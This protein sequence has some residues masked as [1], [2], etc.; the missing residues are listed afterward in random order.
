MAEYE[1]EM[2]QYTE[3][4]RYRVYR[5]ETKRV[6]IADLGSFALH[7]EVCRPIL[8]LFGVD[9]QQQREEQHEDAQNEDLREESMVES[10]SVRGKVR[11]SRHGLRSKMVGITSEVSL[12]TMYSQGRIFIQAVFIRGLID[13]MAFQ[14][15]TL[16]TLI[17]LELSWG[18]QLVL[19]ADRLLASIPRSWGP[20]QVP[21]YFA[22]RSLRGKSRV[23]LRD[24]DFIRQKPFMATGND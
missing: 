20:H 14:F 21:V 8:Y 23:I 3:R 24:L 2:A 10:E 4:E 12:Q 5:A 19:V 9:K 18:L 16:V 13:W 7:D 1:S 17:V 15:Y 22:F 11:S 6:S